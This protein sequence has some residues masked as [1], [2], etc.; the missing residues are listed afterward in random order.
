MLGLGTFVPTKSYYRHIARNLNLPFR[1]L[2]YGP[3][4]ARPGNAVLLTPRKD[5][6]VH[7]IHDYFRCE[8][9]F[10]VCTLYI[11]VSQ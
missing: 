9:P 11:R 2:N 1:C 6:T 3:D 7:P 4:K 8:E 5:G 10:V